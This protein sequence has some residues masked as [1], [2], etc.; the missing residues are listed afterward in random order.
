MPSSRLEKIRAVYLAVAV[1][2]FNTIL[3]AAGVEFLFFLAGKTKG[4]I[5]D[6]KTP[7][8]LSALE[9]ELPLLEKAYP[10]KSREGIVRLRKDMNDL[11]G[12]FRRISL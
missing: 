2:A 6:L 9:R 1:I 7:R 12:R 11:Q 8:T 4:A 3:L 5:K 10:G